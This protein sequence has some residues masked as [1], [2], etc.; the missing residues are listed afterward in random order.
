MSTGTILFLPF[1]VAM[2]AMHLRGHGGYGSGRGGQ[3]GH[4]DHISSPSGSAVPEPSEVAASHQNRILLFQPKTNNPK[5]K[6]P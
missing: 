4:R 5:R 2:I 6:I 1:F 3:K